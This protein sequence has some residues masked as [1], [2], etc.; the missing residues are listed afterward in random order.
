[1]IKMTVT[2]EMEEEELRDLFENCEIKFSKKKMKDLQW[3]LDYNADSVQEQL[4]ESF[5]EVVS[6]MIQEIFE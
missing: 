1:M 6:E 3:E 5:E 2:F 4:E